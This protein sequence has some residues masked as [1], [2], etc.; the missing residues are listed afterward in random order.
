MN[1]PDWNPGCPPPNSGHFPGFGNRCCKNKKAQGPVNWTSG[2]VLGLSMLITGATVLCA[3]I[4]PSGICLVFLGGV[5]I[6]CGYR[7]FK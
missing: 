5:L 3:V 2:K 7:L 1:R 6:Y 4:L